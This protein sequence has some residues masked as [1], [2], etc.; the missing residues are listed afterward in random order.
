MHMNS[1]TITF[2]TTT[3]ADIISICGVPMTKADLKSL[4]YKAASILWGAREA[5]LN[6][7]PNAGVL[8]RW[9]RATCQLLAEVVRSAPDFELPVADWEAVDYVDNNIPVPPED[10]EELIRTLI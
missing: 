3:T 4:T 2:T 1:T 8:S 7:R 10:V 5:D 9:G 6:C